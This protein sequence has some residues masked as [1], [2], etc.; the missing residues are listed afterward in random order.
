MT[1]DCQRIQPLLLDY[2]YDLLEEGEAQALQAHVEAC[3]ACQRE[4]V[5]ARRQQALLGAASRHAFPSLRF[6]PP[7]EAA[8]VVGLPSSRRSWNWKPWAVAASIFLLIA[9][10]GLPTLALL[11]GRP[12]EPV[13]VESA[14][15]EMGSQP[16]PADGRLSEARGMAEPPGRAAAAIKVA[17]EE[18]EGE[19]T[20]QAGPQAFAFQQG[21]AGGEPPFVTH[22]VTDKEAY[23]PGETVFFRAVTLDAL[24][25]R[26]VETDAPL[27]LAF[28]VTDPQGK[29]VT[30]LT[31]QQP[32]GR[33]ADHQVDDAAKASAG[34]AG[35]DFKGLSGVRHGAWSIPEQA[36]AGRYHLR[37]QDAAKS[38]AFQEAS[39][40]VGT[41]EAAGREQELA[42]R[43][44]E[45]QPA[46]VELYPEG[47]RLIAGVPNRVY[48]RILEQPTAFNPAAGA[49][50]RGER[51]TARLLDAQGQAVPAHDL[52]VQ[53]GSLLPNHGRFTFVPQ[54]GQRYQLVVESPSGGL[55]T[56]HWLRAE[57]SGVAIQL[58]QSVLDADTPIT[59]RLISVG[60]DRHLRLVGA[61][62][63]QTIGQVEVHAPAGMEMPV[64]LVSRVAAA[65]VCRL[66]V[67]ERTPGATK[68]SA[69]AERLVFIRPP[70]TLRLE[71]AMK[72]DEGTKDRSMKLFLRAK[73]EQGQ[74][75]P[76]M[77]TLSVTA[78]QP[79]EPSPPAVASPMQ[80][81]WAS[82]IR[83][84]DLPVA[85]ALGSYPGSRNAD[86]DLLL[87]TQAV[88]LN[89]AAHEVM[90]AQRDRAALRRRDHSEAQMR[91]A[92]DNQRRSAA[93]DPVVTEERKEV[94]VSAASSAGPQAPMPSG[95][96]APKSLAQ[97]Q[98]A[99][100]SGAEKADVAPRAVMPPGVA[101]VS[102]VP[103]APADK[104][105]ATA[106]PQP[107]APAKG[108]PFS[109]QRGQTATREKSPGGQVRPGSTILWQPL[110]VLPSGEGYVDLGLIPP[111]L[112]L[113]VT[114]HV[115]T[116]EGLL[117]SRS[118]R[119][120][121]PKSAPSR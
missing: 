102:A 17:P 51:W 90:L 81:L 121:V 71:I 53:N 113:D 99:G 87:G 92:E 28:S 48:F 4:L 98:D 61:C 110:L 56:S 93:P 119:L 63:G 15:V 5:R 34:F 24:S 95:A 118:V 39:F 19:E 117:Q 26:P 7:S 79:S 116:P 73:D 82:E 105:S 35:E 14:R 10:V 9:L 22:L 83:P 114:A 62:R 36:A 57:A 78:R 85:E 25:L 76:S 43:Q 107:P 89:S 64:R 86:W 52:P 1:P 33:S 69:V 65:G 8:V 11:T 103:P 31:G 115:L 88:H 42:R 54:P 50:P 59:L 30:S 40:L 44:T 66:T 46:E 29:Q 55:R 96:S 68:W 106:I 27:H 2:L 16:P 74:A 23:Q 13:P 38:V 18:A 72:P 120:S 45:R 41:N 12:G 6:E 47:G 32:R 104:S 109:L 84:E 112:D 94:T 37:V 58:A 49:R 80:F 77:W 97:K 111:G 75:V 100:V 67:L 70:K 3:P 20:S 91:Q 60:R 21:I 108:E 101:G